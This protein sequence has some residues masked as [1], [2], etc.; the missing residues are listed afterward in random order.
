MQTWKINNLEINWETEAGKKI[1]ELCKALKENN[2]KPE[3]IL[4]GSAPLQLLVNKTFLSGDIDILSNDISPKL[5][6]MGFLEGQ[7]HPHF[8]VCETNT[9]RTCK[10]W[11]KRARKESIEGVTVI[12]PHPIDILVGKLLRLEPKD[13]AAFKMCINKTGHPTEPEL[14]EAL[15]TALEIYKPTFGQRTS[16]RC[17]EA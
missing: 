7:S 13:I 2:I 9:F 14:I 12:I 16:R 1:V 6:E 8:E 15:Q 3:L 11:I 4:F 10:N 5:K 17:L